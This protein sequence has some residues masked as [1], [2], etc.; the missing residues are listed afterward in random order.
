MMITLS[1][2]GRVDQQLSTRKAFIDRQV[3]SAFRG[4]HTKG[5]ASPKAKINLAVEPTGE[6]SA[7][8][9]ETLC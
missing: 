5:S 1:V 2:Q 4:R 3:E 6:Q 9:E 8:K 7:P